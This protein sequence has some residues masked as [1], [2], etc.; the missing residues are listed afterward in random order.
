M[1][2]IAIQCLNQFF[3][4]LLFIRHPN[5]SLSELITIRSSFATLIF[6]VIMNRNIKYY[7]YS[8]IPRSQY[9]TLAL[10]CAQGSFAFMCLY[11]C[12]KYF[13]LVITALV[14]NI[15]PLLI[16]LFSRILYKVSLSS[17]DKLTLL[18]SFCGV[19][20]LISGTVTGESSSD[21][22]TLLSGTSKFSTGEL[23]IPSILLIIIPFNGAAIN[24]FLR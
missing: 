16:A 5:L 9:M 3:G 11:T 4:K 19:I 20:L 2:F 14:Q 13:P 15:S 23:I 10:R 17:I 21:E 7:L 24:L 6:L 1:A 18:I 8:S 12:I 22:D